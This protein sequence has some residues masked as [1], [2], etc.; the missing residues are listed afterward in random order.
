MGTLARFFGGPPLFVLFRLAIISVFVGI[1]LSA[2]GLNPLDILGSIEALLIRIYNM[3]FDAI[4]WGWRYFLLGAVIV[5]PL[6]LIGRI[7]NAFGSGRRGPPSS[8]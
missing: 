3:G 7:F 8:H 6:W 5:F 2:L 1:L 4:E